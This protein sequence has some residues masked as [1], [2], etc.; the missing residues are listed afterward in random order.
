[1]RRFSVALLLV[2][3]LGCSGSD[4]TPEE[5][6]LEVFE[7]VESASGPSAAR[8]VEQLEEWSGR[9]VTLVG[10]FN[11][12]NF[13]HGVLELKSGL[14]VY[15]PHFDLFME[16]DDWFKYIGKKCWAQGVLHTY[17]KNIEGYRGPS[18]ELSDFSG[19]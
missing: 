5:Q 19:P 16:G 3:A 8:D 7:K 10:I 6:R 18:L 11:H 12:L 17:T 13:K 9:N 2:G 14:K 15:L 4:R 1:M